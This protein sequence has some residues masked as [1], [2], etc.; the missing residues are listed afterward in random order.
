MRTNLVGPAALTLALLPALQRH[1]APRIVNVGSSS[2]LRA[3]RVEP[4]MF[5]RAERDADLSAYAQSK[6]GLMQLS[7]LLRRAVPGVTTVDAHPGIVWTPMLQQVWGRFAPL[8]QASGLSGV[9]F[10]SA[11][12]GATT[13]LVAALAPPSPPRAWGERS[14]WQRGWRRGPY[15]VNCRPGGFASAESRDLAAARELWALLEG[16]VGAVARQGHREVWAAARGSRSA[17]VT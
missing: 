14:R 6:L 12:C 11:E 2:H 13:I 10:K 9:V 17:R 15:F 7:L 4:S 8:L 16:T 5:A 3:A 1:A